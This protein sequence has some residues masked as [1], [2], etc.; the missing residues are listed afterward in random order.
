MTGDMGV[1][2]DRWL[3]A[4]RLFRTRSLATTAVRGGHVQLN[5][6]RAKPARAVTVG[7]RLRVSREGWR[8]DLIVRELSER[9]G[10]ARIAATLYEETTASIERR[11]LQREER[12]SQR[13]AAPPGRPDKKARRE[14]RRLVRGD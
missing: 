14:L 11:A 8:M 4:A 12:K 3:W 2:L 6:V 1:R 5:G 10:P 7:D 9:R 13:A